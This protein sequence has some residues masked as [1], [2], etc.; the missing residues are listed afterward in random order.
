MQ[1]EGDFGEQNI[2]Q[3]FIQVLMRRRRNP[4]KVPP[5]KPEHEHYTRKQHS[6]KAKEAYETED[7]ALEYLN[8]KQKLNVLVWHPYLCKVCSKFHICILQKR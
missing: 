6:C 2:E 1:R 8:L 4:N 3:C 7:D 5:L